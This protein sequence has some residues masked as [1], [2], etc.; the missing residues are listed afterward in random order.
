M[1]PA[2][3]YRLEGAPGAASTITASLRLAPLR[4]SVLLSAKPDS[5]LAML[6][7]RGA[8]SSQIGFSPNGPCVDASEPGCACDVAAMP[9]TTVIIR[10]NRSLRRLEKQFDGPASRY[11]LTCDCRA[12]RCKDGTLKEKGKTSVR[13]NLFDRHKQE[14]TGKGDRQNIIGAS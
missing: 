12:A 8:H 1:D 2:G 7:R 14:R 3:S 5:T 6:Y 9:P 4:W 11:Q 10:P 13:F